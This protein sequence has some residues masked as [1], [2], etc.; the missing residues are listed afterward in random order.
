M[1]IVKETGKKL[2]AFLVI[3]SVLVNSMIFVSLARA[4]DTKTEIS[5]GVKAGKKLTAHVGK[6]NIAEKTYTVRQDNVKITIKKGSK[7]LSELTYQSAN[8]K[9]LTISKKGVIS[10]KKNGTT[11]V[12]IRAKYQKKTLTTWIKIKVKIN[13]NSID[14]PQE[15]ISPTDAPVT[16]TQPAGETTSVPAMQ[17]TTEPT[18][19]P[20]QS[21]NDNT[22]RPIVYMTRSITARGIAESIS[23]NVFCT[24]WQGGSEGFHRRAATQSLS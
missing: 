14:K 20:S 24:C 23:G 15:T 3:M 17:P 21:T 11:K 19:Q 10:A 1:G 8:K 4:D 9:V 18:A 22:E 12:T 16:T 13:G 5:I 7:K 2:A 6:K